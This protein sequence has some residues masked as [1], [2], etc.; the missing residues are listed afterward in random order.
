[1][2][3]A[4]K[5]SNFFGNKGFCYLTSR[6]LRQRVS[7]TLCG[8]KVMFRRDYARMPIGGKE[9]W[10]DFDLLFG[11]AR[12]RLRILEIPVPYQERRAGKSKMRAMIEVWYFL[13][14]CWHG[15]RMLRFP[16][17]FPWSRERDTV[18]GWSEVEP[19]V[20]ETVS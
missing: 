20:S 4:M 17:H 5:V 10:G 1:E 19:V 8:T 14:S 2:G 9:R 15:W 3:R 12:L 6:V 16:H 13:R 18:G 7:D 11:A